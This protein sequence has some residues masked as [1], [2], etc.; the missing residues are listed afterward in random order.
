MPGELLEAF[1]KAAAHGIRICLTPIVI[2][3]SVNKFSGDPP[4]SKKA[5]RRR[6][7]AKQQS[8]VW[9]ATGGLLVVGAFVVI[10]FV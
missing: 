9:L 2:D 3:E 8:L 5:E 4:R 10:V 7:A 6:N 1:I